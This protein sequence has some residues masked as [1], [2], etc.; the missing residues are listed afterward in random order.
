MINPTTEIKKG[1]K[2]LFSAI[3]YNAATV[4]YYEGE[5]MVTDY[6]ILLQDVDY[7]SESTKNDFYGRSS[8]RFEIVTEAEGKFLTKDADLILNS[9]LLL[10]FPTPRT[11]GLTVTGFQVIGMKKDIGRAIKEEAGNGG[12]IVRRPLELNFFINQMNLT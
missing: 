5:G 9:M 6:Q 3:T 8:A 2:N 10:L 7:Q 1:F 12:K 11:N 4:P